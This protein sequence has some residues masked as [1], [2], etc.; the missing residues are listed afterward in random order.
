MLNQQPGGQAIP[1]S[2][3]HSRPTLTLF[4]KLS[5]QKITLVFASSS[6]RVQWNNSSHIS[7]F[8]GVCALIFK[9]RNW[10]STNEYFLSSSGY[11]LSSDIVDQ[12]DKSF[13]FHIFA[14]SDSVVLKS[15][16][17]SF[18]YRIIDS[19]YSLKVLHSSPCLSFAPLINVSVLKQT[20]RSIY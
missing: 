8:A 3:K 18:S 13:R 4:Q 12:F 7:G 5:N 19:G 14:S 6:E 10:L 20:S 11:V 9:D 15:G 1:V 17:N 16:K 2:D